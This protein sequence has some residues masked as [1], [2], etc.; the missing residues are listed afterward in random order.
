MAYPSFYSSYTQCTHNSRLIE[1]LNDLTS[2]I[3]ALP[4]SSFGIT[5]KRYT[6]SASEQQKRCK[7]KKKNTRGV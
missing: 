7:N 3:I 2:K 6:H 4:S 5:L 1:F